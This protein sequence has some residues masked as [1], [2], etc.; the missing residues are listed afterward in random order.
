[1]FL[2]CF[3][4]YRKLYHT[5][6][7]STYSSLLQ[8]FPDL[9]SGIFLS[10]SGPGGQSSGIAARLIGHYV[11]DRLL[12]ETPWL[13]E[14]TACTYP[15]PWHPAHEP[16]NTVSIE[17]ETSKPVPYKAS[18]YTGVYGHYGFG[19]IRIYTENNEM[20]M[21]YGRYGRARLLATSAP[22]H[23][24]GTWL[25]KLWY[26]SNQDGTKLFQMLI[27]DD[28]K[29]DKARHL[30]TNIE[31]TATVLTTF[32]RDLDI[33]NMPPVGPRDGGMF[34]CDNQKMADSGLRL[35]AQWSFLL[36][37]VFSSL[38]FLLNFP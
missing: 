32:E 31:I 11:A 20:Y 18:M 17:R 15:A 19:V 10:T 14:S 29:K 13:N 4:G 1:M 30:K 38:R 12:G 6:G 34:V 36:F 37:L 33:D 9:K 23:F 3:S 16:D 7:I 21:K 35:S 22:H 2:V 26:V 8:I 5:G 28:F 24:I 27:F 25:D